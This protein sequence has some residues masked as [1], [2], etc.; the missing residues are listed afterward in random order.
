MEMGQ[1]AMKP[2]FTVTGGLR[3]LGIVLSL[4]GCDKFDFKE[5][6]CDYPDEKMCIEVLIHSNAS[7]YFGIEEEKVEKSCSEDGGEFSSDDPCSRDDLIDVCLIED[8]PIIPDK[9]FGL[10]QIY[11]YEGFIDPEEHC[12]EYDGEYGVVWK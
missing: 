10:G 9:E 5:V 2:G 6:S 1:V 8:H 3:A 12:A 7:G 11:Y 4:A